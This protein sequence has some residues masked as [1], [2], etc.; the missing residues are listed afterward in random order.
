MRLRAV[1]RARWQYSGEYLVN[2]RLALLLLLEKEHYCVPSARGG[3]VQTSSLSEASYDGR[4]TSQPL[5]R[6]HHVRLPDFAAWYRDLVSGNEQ[7]LDS[8]SACWL[9][10]LIVHVVLLIT[11]GVVT[12]AQQGRDGSAL[13]VV[14]LLED[15]SEPEIV[16]LAFDLSVTDESLQDVGSVS[17]GT[18][19]V[20]AA[21]PTG[22]S[23]DMPVLNDMGQISTEFSGMEVTL[24]ELASNDNAGFVKDLVGISGAVVNAHG[25]TGSVDRITAE[26]LAKLESGNVLIAWLMDASESLRPRREQIINHFTRVYDELDKLAEEPGDAL[27]TS[28]GAFGAG[29]D[30]MTS[31]PTADRDAI[32]AA[33]RNI[34]AEDTGVENVFSAV[35]ATAAEYAKYVRAGRQVMIIVV[36]DE[37]GNDVEELDKALAMLERHRMTVHVIGPV[38]PFAQEEITV[39]WTDPETN[40]THNLPVDA[41]PET[42]YI[43]QAALNVWHRGPGAAPRSSGFGPYGLTRLTHESG[44]MYLLHD[45]GRI[46]GPSFEVDQLLRYRPDYVADGSYKKLADEH[47]LRMAVLRTAQATNQYLTEPLPRTLLAAGIQFEI[48]PTKKKLHEIAEILDRGLGVLQSA[49]GVRNE[50]TSPRWLAHFDLLKGRLL[51]NKVRCYSY[52]KLLDEMYDEPKEPE[53]GTKNAWQATS[54][55]DPEAAERDLPPAERDDAQSARQHLERVVQDHSKTPWAAIANDEL[56]FAL[57]FHWQ[58]AF[59]EPPEGV[60]LPWDKKPWSELTEAQKEAKVAFEKKKEAAKIRKAKTPDKKRVPP[61]L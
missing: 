15:E 5:T 35:H 32:Q 41:G 39:K 50:E 45:D 54:C 38:A 23:V 3:T 49:E 36:T 46:P 37:S 31:K 21:L 11:L 25:D 26:I 56:Q 24:Q 40:E 1:H 7:M 19:E 60:A 20:A 6:N 57:C 29:L 10:S 47:P 53:D 58:E 34:K 43:E 30:V 16:E 27:L 9:V 17:L 44:G 13:I 28:V 51:A 2:G 52:A 61:K 8:E 12:A 33:V 18:V 55:P 22:D 14:P 59:M 48:R 42:A 4:A